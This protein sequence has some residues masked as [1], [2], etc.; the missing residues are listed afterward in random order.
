[1]FASEE[2][3]R[4]NRHLLLPEIG[5]KGQKLLK[6]AKV[7][8]IGAGG[9]GCPVLQYL[10][11]AG[12]G[13]IGIVEFDTVNLSNLQRQILYSANEVG[14]PK[15]DI[16]IQKLKANN[17]FVKFDAY[18]V[19]L[20]RSN[21]LDILRKYDLVVDCSDNFATRYLVN[22]ACVILDK[23]FVFGAIYRFE[24]Q[25]SVFNL[26]NKEGVRSAT[27]R[28]LFPN[29]PS[30]SQSP[31]CDTAG[32]LGMVAGMVGILQANEVIKIV[33]KIGNPLSN[34][35]LILD[36]LSLK[37]SII[38][39]SKSKNFQKITGLKM[40]ETKTAIIK[41]K[42]KE[43][44]VQELEEKL[45][46]NAD[47]QLIDVRESFEFEI[48]NLG[49][50]LMPMG[51]I[52]NFI[53]RISKEKMVLIYCHHGMRSANIIRYLE[54]KYAFDNLYNLTGGIDAWAREIDEGMERY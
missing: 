9:L 32:V 45:N 21:I 2:L 40:E 10:T 11:A 12:V 31:D 51:E 30:Q 27:Y 14:L 47:I 38:R 44:S 4:Y 46:Q 26:E 49:G 48:C 53:N 3:K 5:E 34:Q 42:M 54:Q 33:C 24:G 41:N 29:E 19:K 25:V 1:M 37:N 16:A 17:P 28:C 23:P 39:F 20:D 7:L 52:D 36:L 35:L 22:D 50:E 15:I 6:E 18:P 8:V 13:T 43:I